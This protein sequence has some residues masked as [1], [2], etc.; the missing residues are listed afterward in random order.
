MRFFLVLRGAVVGFQGKEESIDLPG[1]L[2]SIVFGP[3][4]GGPTRKD[5]LWGFV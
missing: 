1:L 3:V 5:R 2:T 4:L